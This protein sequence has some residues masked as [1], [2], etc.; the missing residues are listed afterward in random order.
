MIEDWCSRVRAHELW[1]DI[2]VL[3]HQA[4]AA[5]INENFIIR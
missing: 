1:D 3:G 5:G 4:A 2:D